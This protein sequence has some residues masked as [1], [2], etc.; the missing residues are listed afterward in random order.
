MAYE[1][2]RFISWS[3]GTPITGD[4]LGQMSTNIDQV[5]EATDDNPRGL[6]EITQ[7]TSNLPDTTGWTD[8]AEH[9]IA[10]LTE[11]PPADDRVT[12]PA[13]RWYR[14]TVVFPGFIIKGRGAEDSNFYLKMYEDAAAI[15]GAIWR[16]TPHTFDY[17]DVS[18]NASVTTTTVK[19]SGYPTRIGAGTY[20]IVL[21]SIAGFTNKSFSVAVKRDQGASATNAPAYYVPAGEST[22]QFYAEDIGGN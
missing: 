15:P 22:L 11:V 7:V 4:R 16:F 5:K 20:S 8:F 12:L 19:S 2:Y 17:Y 13:S 9:T 14:L 18:S 1:N 6:V 3:L 21:D 10:S